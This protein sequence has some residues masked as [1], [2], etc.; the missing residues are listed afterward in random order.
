VFNISLHKPQASTVTTE[1]QW[2]NLP[3]IK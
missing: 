2:Q 1:A 3:W